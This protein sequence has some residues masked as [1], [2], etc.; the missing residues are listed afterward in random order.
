KT[1]RG[2][3]TPPTP[4]AIRKVWGGTFH[5]VG[6]RLL[7]LHGSAIGVDPRFTIHDKTDAEDLLDVLRTELQLTEKHPDFPKKGTCQ[8]VHRRFDCVLVDEYQ[9]TNPIQAQI[10][11]R[12]RPDGTGLTV[13]GDDAQSIYSFRG[14]TVRNILDFPKQFP[15][16]TIL[17]LEENYRSTEPIL[18]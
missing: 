3:K 1:S 16:T 11:Q 8:A 15:G 18:E 5:A 17:K 10:L 9:D 6:A 7:R 14:A 2:K 13:V 4:A 12:L